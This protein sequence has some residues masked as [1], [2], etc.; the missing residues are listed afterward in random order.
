[1]LTGFRF[2]GGGENMISDGGD[3]R[4]LASEMRAGDG[5]VGCGAADEDVLAA[6]C[7]F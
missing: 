1:M 5:C 4:C 3:E 7:D 2:D 6:C